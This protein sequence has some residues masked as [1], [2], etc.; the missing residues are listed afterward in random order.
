MKK[1]NNF[2]KS[3]YGLAVSFIIIFMLLLLLNS[4]TIWAAD[5]YAFYNNV[6]L[7]EN[8]FSLLR[9]FERS[10]IFYLTWT[11]RFLSTFINYIFLYFPKII[12]NVVNAGMYTSLI[13]V[14]YKIVKKDETPNGYLSITI[15]LVTWLLV[16]SIG[17]V[18]FWQ[19]GSVI[20]LWMFFLVSLLILFYTKLVK[21]ESKIKDNLLNIILMFIL[22]IAAGNGFETNS[23]V[24]LMFLL[25]VLLYN[26]FIIKNKTPKWSIMGFIG[27][28]IGASTNF[29]SPGNSVRMQQMGSS[30]NIFSKVIFGAGPWFYNGIVRSKIFITLTLLILIYL[31][32]VLSKKKSIDKKTLFTTFSVA[33]FIGALI[34]TIGFLLPPNLSGFLDWFY[35][36]YIKFWFI[37]LILGFFLILMVVTTVVNYKSFFKGT[38]STT[39][40][41]TLIY[42]LSGILGVGSYIMT[43][44]AWPRSYMGM[45]LTF[46][47][48]IIYV[49]QRIK[50]KNK[51]IF[52][53]IFIIISLA[54]AGLYCY[55]LKDA[56]NATKWNNKTKNIIKENISA[57]EKIIYVDTFS[58]KSSYNGASI[59]KWV[60]PIEING[61]INPDYEW[62]NRNITNYYFKDADAWNKGR[63]IIGR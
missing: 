45:S 37:L 44:T 15:F 22:G 26:K 28:L 2:I 6:W 23:I 42:T 59:E 10:K 5:D 40:Y 39:N 1:I 34:I 41:L 19:I 18:M 29:F 47:I 25:L 24:L 58:S 50:L 4:L 11:G 31:I 60:I 49:A 53:V 38:D 33:L 52:P 16:P 63:R 3:K 43:P 36:N 14:I 13:Y 20:Y 48:A 30:G 21:K 46:I 55:T 35:P 27:S 8:G 12:F 32:Y 61:E 7:G 17:Q 62:I 54:S 51:Y 56:Y 57:D 9:I